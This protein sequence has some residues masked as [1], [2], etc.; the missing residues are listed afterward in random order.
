MGSSVNSTSN[1]AYIVPPL[2]FLYGPPAS[3]AWKSSEPDCVRISCP[4]YTSAC[5]LVPLWFFQ[6]SAAC[7]TIGPSS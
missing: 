2:D 4:S 7:T 3:F 6:V 1:E 5:A